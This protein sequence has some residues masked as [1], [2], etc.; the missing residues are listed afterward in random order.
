MRD[1]SGTAN[2]NGPSIHRLADGSG[3]ETGVVRSLHR[4]G[5]PDASSL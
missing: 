2:D 1:H 3:L 4:G 5:R